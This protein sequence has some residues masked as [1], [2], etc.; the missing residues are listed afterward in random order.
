MGRLKAQIEGFFCT[1]ER[2]TGKH[3]MPSL[4]EVE[5]TSIDAPDDAIDL[6]PNQ[7]GPRILGLTDKS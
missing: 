7:I 5:D 1:W 4:L 3:S 2:G 6:Y